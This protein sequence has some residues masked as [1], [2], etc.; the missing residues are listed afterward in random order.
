[1]RGEEGGEE[2]VCLT[3]EQM[4]SIAHECK[5][6]CKICS[7]NLD[8]EEAQAENGDKDQLALVLGRLASDQHSLAGNRGWCRRDAVDA[9]AAATSAAIGLVNVDN[10]SFGDIR[11]TVALA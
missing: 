5:R 9:A 2:S 6:L 4:E 7:K 8:R 3:G 10:N 1:M 11:S